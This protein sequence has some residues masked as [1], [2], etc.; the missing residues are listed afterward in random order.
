[1]IINAAMKLNDTDLTPIGRSKARSYRR[2]G[3]LT[4]VVSGNTLAVVQ[5]YAKR[6]A[7][8]ETV[9]IEECDAT[10]LKVRDLA[11]LALAHF[12]RLIDVR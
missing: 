6:Y 4:A 5:G 3:H 8:Q 7:T 12:S 11:G 1:M 2:G 9:T 10:C